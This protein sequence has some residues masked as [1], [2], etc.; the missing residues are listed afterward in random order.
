MYQIHADIFR[1][2]EL[3][4]K[5]AKHFKE[6]IK[7]INVRNEIEEHFGKSYCR[8]YVNIE[9]KE[10]S[11][12]KYELYQSIQHFFYRYGEKE[13]F[14]FYLLTD[15]DRTE[16]TYLLRN[17]EENTHYDYIWNLL[18]WYLEQDRIKVNNAHFKS[19]LD[20]RDIQLEKH[21]KR[22]QERKLLEDAVEEVA[23]KTGQLIVVKQ[24]NFGNLRIGRVEKVI[25]PNRTKS[26]SLE[27]YEIKKDLTPGRV[28]IDLW[29]KTD[30]Y[31]VI[32]PNELPTGITKVELL[33]SVERGDNI[34]GLIWR[35]PNDLW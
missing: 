12:K 22:D 9:L 25:L 13:Y 27:L 5:I 19:Q 31:A 1:K 10:D 15:G 17:I 20:L 23:P 7:E 21:K 26:F 4:V 11:N 33:A 29:S 32:Q 28:K 18:S 16:K 30:I 8:V 6:E 34:A 3:Y 35:R 24:W 2:I 14:S